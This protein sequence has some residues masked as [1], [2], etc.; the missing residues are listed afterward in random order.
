MMEE[1]INPLP[2]EAAFLR[3]MFV[4]LLTPQSVLELYEL[5]QTPMAV[6]IRDPQTLD[7]AV[8]GRLEHR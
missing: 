7:V 8:G 6:A 4:R 2:R 1:L 3:D 5:G